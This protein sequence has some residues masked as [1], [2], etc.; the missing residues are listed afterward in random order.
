MIGALVYQLG[1][2]MFG[3]EDW[4][5]VGLFGSL[6]FY[7]SREIRDREKGDARS[8]YKAVFYPVLGILMLFIIVSFVAMHYKRIT[9]KQKASVYTTGALGI[10]LV[11]DIWGFILCSIYLS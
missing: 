2:I 11:V 3:L 7:I 8:D 1:T 4:A 9:K 10:L 6:N 5:I